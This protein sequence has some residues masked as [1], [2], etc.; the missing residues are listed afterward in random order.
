MLSN[1]IWYLAFQWSKRACDCQCRLKQVCSSRL[2]QWDEKNCRCGCI[3]KACPAGKVRNPENCR[4]ERSFRDIMEPFS[5]DFR[6][7]GEDGDTDGSSPDDFWG[8]F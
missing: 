7:E 2:K 5:R 6:T 3:K 4:C 8:D 1:F